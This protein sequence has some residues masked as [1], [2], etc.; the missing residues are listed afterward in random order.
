MYKVWHKHPGENIHLWRL[1]TWLGLWKIPQGKEQK[2]EDGRQR[3]RNRMVT[4][5]TRLLHCWN[6]TAFVLFNFFK[7]NTKVE[8]FH[9]HSHFKVLG[10]VPWHVWGLIRR[11]LLPSWLPSLQ[12]WPH[13]GAIRTELLAFVLS[14]APCLCFLF[15]PPS[16][17]LC[18]ISR[19]ALLS[20]SPCPH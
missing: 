3:G 13:H 7:S 2:V 11:V 10:L 19:S 17:L 4:V 16:P 8:G 12:P 1:S 6:N 15:A 14:S 5:P 9:V 18:I 20:Q